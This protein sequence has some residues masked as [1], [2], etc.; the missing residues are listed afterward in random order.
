MGRLLQ[1]YKELND[2]FNDIGKKL[3]KNKSL[4][5]TKQFNMDIVKI[6]VD[7]IIASGKKFNDV[8]KESIYLYLEKANINRTKW[9][10][11]YDTLATNF[12]ES[13]PIVKKIEKNESHTHSK[14]EL[15]QRQPRKSIFSEIKKITT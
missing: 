9:Q 6:L 11:I 13:V 7:A 4:K 15:K 3:H 10:G 8:P 2:T 12:K 5:M 1:K 14:T